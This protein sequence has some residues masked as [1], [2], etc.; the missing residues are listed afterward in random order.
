MT[1]AGLWLA[2]AVGVAVVASGCDRSG[3]P[4]EALGPDLP[5]A[6]AVQPAPAGQV[7]VTT[8]MGDVTFWPY[9]GVDFSGTPQDPM[10][11]VLV[12]H[13]DPRVLRAALM[14][15]DGDRT[16]FGFPDAFP[17][18]CTWQDAI[19]GNQTT[20]GA[21]AG[22]V[23]NGVQLECGPYDLIRFHVRF[24][25]VGGWT[26]GGAHLEVLVPATTEHQ[27][28]H[29][30]VAEQLVAADFIRAGLVDPAAIPPPTALVNEV[31]SFKAIPR[32]LFD[33]LDSDLQAALFGPPF[34]PPPPAPADVPTPTDG[35]VSIVHL[36][37]AVATTAGIA[38]Q[39]FT[40]EFNQVIPT[41]A[42]FGA[43]YLWVTGPVRLRQ[44]VVMT[45]SGTFRSQFHANGMLALTP[46]D[47]S[48]TPP[49][50]VGPTYRAKVTEHH[51]NVVTDQVTL[52]SQLI[53]Q[54]EL[55]PKGPFRGR[56]FITL[57]VGPGGADN[58]HV[59][60]TRC[61]G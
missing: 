15:L 25:E 31:P 52:V 9:T 33:A 49:T 29:W 32:L 28:I 43:G 2:T 53:I 8:P 39:D 51:K 54:A 41:P 35:Q 30:E 55:P 60:P 6:A 40:I 42:C 58:V 16:A 10:N 5:P 44:Q 48:T 21:P 45:P 7:T 4:A 17:F 14:M 22:W 24:F 47:P 37:D 19:G 57:N 26:L 23:G 11:L 18:N 27:V 61:D 13:T 34:P 59:G 50:P 1:R 36:V 56:L 38:R 12:G 46:V 3:D 20:W